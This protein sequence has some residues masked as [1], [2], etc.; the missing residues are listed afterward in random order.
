MRCFSL[1]VSFALIF[2]AVNCE[3]TEKVEKAEK[4]GED[5]PDAKEVCEFD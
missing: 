5:V 2:A 4:A 3:E 1:I